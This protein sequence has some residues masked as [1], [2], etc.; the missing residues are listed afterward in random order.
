MCNKTLAN[1]CVRCDSRKR[2]NKPTDF[3]TEAMRMLFVTLLPLGAHPPD[4]LRSF[5]VDGHAGAVANCERGRRIFDFPKSSPSTDTL[6]AHIE[7]NSFSLAST[8]AKEKMI[9]ETTTGR[10]GKST[11]A[12]VWSG[13]FE[14][15]KPVSLLLVNPARAREPIQLGQENEEERHWNVESYKEF[16]T[17]RIQE[18]REAERLTSMSNPAELLRAPSTP[19]IGAILSEMCIQHPIGDGMRDLTTAEWLNA[20][21]LGTSTSPPQSLLDA[22]HGCTDEFICEAITAERPAAGVGIVLN[23]DP[24]N[25]SSAYRVYRKCDKELTDQLDEFMKSKPLLV[26]ALL[27]IKHYEYETKCVQEAMERNIPLESR[28]MAFA[29]ADNRQRFLVDGSL[30]GRSTLSQHPQFE[31]E[32]IRTDNNVPPLLQRQC[33]LLRP[34]HASGCLFPDVKAY[35]KTSKRAIAALQ[36]LPNRFTDPA[37]V[38]VVSALHLHLCPSAAETRRMAALAISTAWGDSNA[39][40]RLGVH[41]MPLHGHLLRMTESTAEPL[42][43][44]PADRALLKAMENSPTMEAAAAFMLCSPQGAV[45]DAAT[46][47]REFNASILRKASDRTTIPRVPPLRKGDPAVPI[48]AI[49]AALDRQPLGEW[50]SGNETLA[51]AT[52]LASILAPLF[53]FQ[54]G[55]PTAYYI[56]PFCPSVGGGDTLGERHTA[57]LL[58]RDCR[59]DLFVPN[60]D[61]TTKKHAA[62]CALRNI[63][64]SVGPPTATPCRGGWKVAAEA[65]SSTFS[66]VR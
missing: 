33:V 34:E 62:E 22:L 52:A 63:L 15:R 19:A 45:P 28:S 51:T 1:Q 5:D 65:I 58:F 32:I 55:H 21:V 48:P 13:T 26:N 46:L 27:T 64:E 8:T 29:K 36:R 54:P 41:P 3:I 25:F 7:A 61:N 23:L 6:L 14:H 31:T 53:G 35:A 10:D 40:V 50:F 49:T 4:R 11:T 12:L 66:S 39:A 60:L 47:H 38:S 17:H 42:A 56:L 16:V 44:S 37:T 18:V 30:R 59:D 43:S 24:L 20:F 2:D 57:R 9:E